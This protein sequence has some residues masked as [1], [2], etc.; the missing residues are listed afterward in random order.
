MKWNRPSSEWNLRRYDILYKKSSES[1]YSNGAAVGRDA[2]Q[3]TL[4]GLDPNTKYDLYIKYSVSQDDTKPGTSLQSEAAYAYGVLSKD[5][6]PDSVTNLEVEASPAKRLTAS[7]DAVSGASGYDLKL[8]KGGN[9]IYAWQLSSTSWQSNVDLTVGVTHTIAVRARKTNANLGPWSTR[10]GIPLYAAPGKVT[11]V[12]GDARDSKSRRVVER[13][14]GSHGL[15]G[16]VEI[17]RDRTGI[18][19]T[20]RIR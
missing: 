13:G 14:F 5:T 3:H 11:G 8:S 10:T 12:S 7:W 16:A 4:K 2:I 17:R 9:D 18:Q 6:T 15:R 20:G 19:I 1:D